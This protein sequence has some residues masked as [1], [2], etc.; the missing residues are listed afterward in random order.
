MLE[1]GYVGVL[2]LIVRPVLLATAEYDPAKSWACLCASIFMPLVNTSSSAAPGR[3]RHYTFLVHKKTLAATHIAALLA[4]KVSLQ[5]YAIVSQAL[6]TA[7]SSAGQRTALHPYAIEAKQAGAAIVSATC[8]S[9]LQFSFTS[10]A[11]GQT[12]STAA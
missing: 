7:S 10:T 5:L 6:P 12:A 11:E 9:V 8:A 1:I 3:A 2:C 4:H